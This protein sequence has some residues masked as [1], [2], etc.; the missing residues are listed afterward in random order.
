MSHEPDPIT[1]YISS[2]DIEYFQSSS[3]ITMPLSQTLFPDE[4]YLLQYGLR[5]IGFNA[6]AFNI[7]EEQKNN[8]LLFALTYDASNVI[9]YPGQII[10]PD[11]NQVGN[12]IHKRHHHH[13]RH[14]THPVDNYRRIQISTPETWKSNE[15]PIWERM[16]YKP[17][18]S[19]DDNDII[20][21]YVEFVIPD[22]YYTLE[23]LFLYLNGRNHNDSII[24]TCYF[25]DY[26]EDISAEENLIPIHMDWKKESYGYSI[27]I[28]DDS[29]PLTGYDFV[30]TYRT[31]DELGY[32][33][34]MQIDEL[35]PKLLSVTILPH[36][37]K[38][39]LY[40]ILFTNY[41]TQDP[42]VPIS[43]P[44]SNPRT[45]FNPPYGI[46]FNFDFSFESDP[47][48]PGKHIENVKITELGN[49]RTYD[50]PNNIFPDPRRQINTH[51]YSA[52]Y[53]PSLDPTYIDVEISL[54]NHS[55]DGRSQRNILTRIFAIDAISGAN[56]Y[57]R[58]WE[59]PKKTSLDSIVGFSS[60]TLEFKAHE[61][62]WNFFNL[63]F[64]IELEI[65][66]VRILTDEDDVDP[67]AE[68]LRSLPPTDAIDDALKEAG[69]RQLQP[70]H[71]DHFS[72]V[73]HRKHGSL[74]M[75]KKRRR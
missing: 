25:R 2:D 57:Y 19:S 44:S 10:H 15:A 20:I 40:N 34:N 55:M 24:P 30:Q 50:I 59:N 39:E 68:A 18:E 66:Q 52:Y 61:A 45:G 63:E 41:N 13:H 62:K 27:G 22:G 29:F 23:S 11:P 43:S 53:T 3:R 12:T 1:L 48:T 7:T 58:F 16:S 26:I 46:Q 51:I 32:P 70:F 4:G 6:A 37:E 56:S 71:P 21:V 35:F 17:I 75:S 72:H 14:N 67:N 42:N 49:E 74:T 54:P 33:G 69:E 47:N 73:A 31:L 36:P 65:S 5:A 9:G 60:I 28:V 38:E 64:S 8:R